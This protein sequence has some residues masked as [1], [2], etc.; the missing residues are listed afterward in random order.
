VKKNGPN[1]LDYAPGR[2]AID[3]RS[4]AGKLLAILIIVIAFL[5]IQVLVIGSIA[6]LTSLWA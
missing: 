4:L 5:L 1:V 2:R 3:W 6:C